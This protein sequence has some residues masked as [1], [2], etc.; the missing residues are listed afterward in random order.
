MF[1][2]QVKQNLPQALKLRISSLS[3]SKS[4]SCYRDMSS[5]RPGKNGIAATRFEPV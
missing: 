3:D 1:L 5:Y 2:H 4:L